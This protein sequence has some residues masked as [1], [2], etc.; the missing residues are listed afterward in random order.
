MSNI[1]EATVVDIS[2]TDLRIKAIKGEQVTL[3]LT[4]V[5]NTESELDIDVSSWTTSVGTVE[6]YLSNINA[7]G[8]IQPPLIRDPTHV[9]LGSPSLVPHPSINSHMNLFLPESLCQ[10]SGVL[11][12]NQMIPTLYFPVS[13][14]Q[15]PSP[16]DDVLVLRILVTYRHGA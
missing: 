16:T 2:T 14:T 9:P 6:A 7:Q 10:K 3:D 13:I 1:V 11:S 12:L 4:F 8:D 5:E 15:G